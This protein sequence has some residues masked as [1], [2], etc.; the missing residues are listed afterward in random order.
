VGELKQ[1]KTKPK[2]IETKNILKK[3]EKTFKKLFVT[4]QLFLFATKVELE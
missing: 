1:K 3:K 4:T 2:R